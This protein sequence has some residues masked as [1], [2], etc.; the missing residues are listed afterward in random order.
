MR[1]KSQRIKTTSP[2][3]LDKYVVDPKRD[4][5]DNLEWVSTQ[6]R[7][8]TTKE[9][10]QRGSHKIYIKQK[11]FCP[12]KSKTKFI[13]VCNKIIK[14]SHPDFPQLRNKSSSFASMQIFAE[15][16]SGNK[17]MD[18]VDAS[19]AGWTIVRWYKAKDWRTLWWRED[20]ILS[21]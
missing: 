6:H 18:I 15:H 5:V 14:D 2:L 19:A 11:R 20:R 10:E 16:T 17:L 1:L 13:G 8:K 21:L 12:W 3:S 7:K 4:L 9:D